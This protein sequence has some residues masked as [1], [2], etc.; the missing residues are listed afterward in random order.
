[1]KLKKVIAAMLAG[2]MAL[3]LTACQGG[4]G[5]TGSTAGDSA[6]TKDNAAAGEAASADGELS[7]KLVL[8][9]LADDMKQFADRFMEQNPGVEMEVVV[10]APADYPTT[11]Q[12]ALGAGQTTPDI[13]MGEPQMLGDNVRRFLTRAFLRTWIRRLTILKITQINWSTTW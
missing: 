10:T 5:S 11:V 3:S 2:V 13:I 1:M 4:A 12:A 8:W 7:G 6:A 9:A